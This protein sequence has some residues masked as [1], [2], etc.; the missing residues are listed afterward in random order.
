MSGSLL[1]TVGD[2][3]LGQDPLLA[4]PTPVLLRH[5][6]WETATSNPGAWVLND[7][8]PGQPYEVSVNDYTFV[9]R[10]GS[11]PNADIATGR[12]LEFTVIL[13]GSPTQVQVNLNAIM[14]VL[15]PNLLTMERS[16]PNALPTSTGTT[17]DVRA[18]LADQELAFTTG[19]GSWT[20]YGRY[21][22]VG[23]DKYETAPYNHYRLKI[24]FETSDPWI[25]E[26]TTN[27]LSVPKQNAYTPGFGSANVYG[28]DSPY[29]VYGGPP[30]GINPKTGAPYFWP[31]P[32]LARSAS[33]AV[34]WVPGGEG[35]ANLWARLTGPSENPSIWCSAYA[36]WPGDLGLG[37]DDGL[38]SFTLI[39]L[40]Q[41]TGIG[42]IHYTVYQVIGG[43]TYAFDQTTPD[44]GNY[45][46]LE[47][48]G[49]PP[50][51]PLTYTILSWRKQTVQTFSAGVV[52]PPANQLSLGST[53]FRT[54]HPW[55]F[56]FWPDGG[57]LGYWDNAPNHF[58]RYIA[59][60]ETTCTMFWQRAYWAVV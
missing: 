25:Y 27:Q 19:S 56:Q 18:P 32:P 1:Q 48:P 4:Y 15:K 33:D 11:R 45:F 50:S 2:V 60:A 59:T 49:G 3:Q 39:G 23:L 14:R 38:G 40:G 13:T 16:N 43:T 20:M 46:L 10:H 41:S 26:A 31:G 12:K 8:N 30:Y 53:W 17:I 5:A 6:S 57:G 44:T 9:Q 54:D 28:A 47:P 21:R 52:S 34:R 35:P 29:A 55:S 36:G 37:T 24:K 7:F 42:G 58:Q 22:A 51:S